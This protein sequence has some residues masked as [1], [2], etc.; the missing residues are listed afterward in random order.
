MKRPSKKMAIKLVLF[1]LLGAIVN[2][3]V[4]WGCAVFL[5]PLTKQYQ[6]SGESVR[7]GRYWRIWSWRRTGNTTV[8]SQR[9]PLPAATTFLTRVDP[10]QL[11]PEWFLAVIRENNAPDARIA[12]ACGWP[13]PSLWHHSEIDSAQ[14][15]ANRHGTL[16]IGLSSRSLPWPSPI[17]APRDLPLL[18]LW[19]GFAINTIFY[20]AALW[21]VFATPGVIRRRRRHFRGQCIHCGYDLRGHRIPGA[22]EAGHSAKCPECGKRDSN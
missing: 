10:K 6:T 18:P 22:P 3:A 9:G 12:A 14:R 11:C 17:A 19:P 13:M 7:E 4:A 8:L 2:V 16:S 1:L 5:N 21:V 15:I 20:A